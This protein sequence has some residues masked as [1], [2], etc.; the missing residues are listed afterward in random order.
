MMAVHS[1]IQHMSSPDDQRALPP[2]VATNVWRR[3]ADGWRLLMHH[4][5]PMPAAR[6]DPATTDQRTLH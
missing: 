4:A 3:G 6:Q 1:V 5:S 2:I